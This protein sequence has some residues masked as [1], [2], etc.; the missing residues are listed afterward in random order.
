MAKPTAEGGFTPFEVPTR[1]ETAAPG[2]K[3]LEVVPVPPAPAKSGA[4]QRTP[5]GTQ[6]PAVQSVTEPATQTTASPVENKEK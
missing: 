1:D 2:F 3:P 4:K 6:S 5:K